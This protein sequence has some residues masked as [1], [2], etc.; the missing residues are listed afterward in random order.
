VLSRRGDVVCKPWA[1]QN[2]GLFTKD[3]F[4]LDLRSRTITC[5]A[6]QTVKFQYGATAEFDPDLCSVCPL[7]AQCTKGRGA[8]GRTVRIAEDEALQKR[9]RDRIRTT[10][11]RSRLRERVGVEHRLAH[12]SRKQK[13]RARYVGVRK[14]L[15]DVRRAATVLNLEVIHR[16][17]PLA[18]VA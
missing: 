3:D 7:R 15:F 5:P 11:G 16:V 17:R 12:L 9:L 2:N 13:N 6:G 4:D 10:R 18:K 1:F 14:N 8:S